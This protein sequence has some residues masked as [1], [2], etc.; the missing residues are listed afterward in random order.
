MDSIKI[1]DLQSEIINIFKG[2]N[3]NDNK[4]TLEEKGK[5]VAGLVANMVER[6]PNIFHTRIP[7]EKSDAL[8]DRLV[9]LCK[10]MA[11][12]DGVVGENVE[13]EIETVSTLAKNTLLNWSSKVSQKESQKEAKRP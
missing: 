10:E 2:V 11:I 5:R 3:E 13:A 7:E 9:D 6:R 1:R 12:R 8:F 4:K